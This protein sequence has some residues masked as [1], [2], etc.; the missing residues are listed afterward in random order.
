[1]EGEKSDEFF[2]SRASRLQS[3]PMEEIGL[4]FQSRQENVL[5]A[6]RRY[7]SQG[8]K[9]LIEE[10]PLHVG[11]RALKM[12][13]ESADSRQTAFQDADARGAWRASHLAAL[14]ESYFDYYFQALLRRALIVGPTVGRWTAILYGEK[15]IDC[16]L[17]QQVARELN[18]RAVGYCFIENEEYSYMD[19]VGSRVVELFSSILTDGSGLNF[20]SAGK[21]DPPAQGPWIANGFLKQ[22]YQ[23]IPGFYDR[24]YV[25]GEKPTF[26]CYRYSAFPDHYDETGNYPLSA[27]RY[28]YFDCGPD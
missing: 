8:G 1:M 6:V 13:E 22:R 17:L 26:A 11:L 4:Q 12:S 2:Q 25:R 16:R 5:A 23:F 14:F 7:V 21:S 19:L 18:C 24:A 28:F 27:F 9:R 20:W 10:C 3:P 15:A